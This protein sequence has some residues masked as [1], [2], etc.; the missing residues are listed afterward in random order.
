MVP[1]FGWHGTIHSY[2]A[3][4]GE[5]NIICAPVCWHE[6]ERQVRPILFDWLF[7]MG[8]SFAL[9][10]AASNSGQVLRGCKLQLPGL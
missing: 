9:G 10:I 5:H 7:L 6:L 8:V 2:S 1:V 3:T 4:E